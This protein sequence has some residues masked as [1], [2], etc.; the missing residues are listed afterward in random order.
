MRFLF[1]GCYNV[2]EIMNESQQILYM[3]IR[4]LRITTER[5]GLSLKETAELFRKCAVLP[6]IRESFGIFHVEGDEAVFS[7]VYDY[8]KA[9]GAVH[10]NA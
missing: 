7:E 6:F 10:E 4:I 9:K 2:C 1:F 8:L 5:L 3:Q